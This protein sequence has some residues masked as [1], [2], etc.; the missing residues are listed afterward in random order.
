MGTQGEKYHL[1]PEDV[2]GSVVTMGERRS[3]RDV[4][5]SIISE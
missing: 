3:G 5:G 2:V 1:Q 4:R